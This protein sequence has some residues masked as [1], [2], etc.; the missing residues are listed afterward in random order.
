[1][2]R[3][4]ARCCLERPKPAYVF[5]GRN[6]LDHSRMSAIGFSVEAIGKVHDAK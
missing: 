6:I 1:M 5:D 4:C 3:V 2:E